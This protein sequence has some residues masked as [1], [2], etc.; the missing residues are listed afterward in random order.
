MARH[1]K[2]IKKQ[3]FGTAP[4]F[5][6]AISTILGA[7]MFLRF[8]YAVGN[9]GLIGAFAIIILG[10]I[11][12]IP[13]AMAIAEIATNQ[14]VEGGGEYYIISRSFGFTIGAAIGI[15]LYLSQA[16]SVAFYIIAFAQAFEPVFEYLLTLNFMH[17][18]GLAFILDDRLVSIPALFI[19]MFIVLT[20]GA[21]VGVKALYFVVGILF[22]SLIM[23]FLGSTD[24]K[25]EMSITN[26][27][28]HINNPDTFFQVFAICFPAFTGMTA[29]VGL[30]GDLQ[31]PRRSIPLGTLSATIFGMFVYFA[32]VYK[33]YAAIPPSDLAND[34]LIMQ[35]IAL[36]GPIIP[37][38]LAA[39]TV[40]SALGS[41]LV[42]PRTLQAL[43]NDEV[44]PVDSL[45]KILSRGTKE[46][47]EPFNAT[48]LT[49][50]IAII[51]VII[52]DVNFVAEIISMFFMVTYGAL[53]LISFLE[54]LS[55]DPSYRPTFRSRWY[56]SLI[57]AVSCLII[58]FQINT[59]YAIL[60]IL[61]MGFIYWGLSRYQHKYQQRGIAYLF[62]NT[63]IQ[64]SR[65]I[66]VYLQKRVIDEDDA[67]NWRPLII[68][69][70]THSFERASAFNLLR[71]IAYK[72]G[73]GTYIHYIPGYLSK[74]SHAKSKEMLNQ[75]IRMADITQ[76]NIYLDTLVSPSL[77]STIAQVIQLPS[78]S[79]QDNNMI[80][81]EF[82]KQHPDD[83]LP[84]IV[85]NFSMVKA[86]DVDVCILGSSPKNFGFYKEIHIW[87]TQYDYDIVNLMILLAY[88]IIGHPQWKKADIKL[89]VLYPDNESE[90]QRNQLI[91]MIDSGRLPIS[92]NNVVMIGKKEDIS[93]KHIINQSSKYADLTILGIRTDNIKHEGIDVFLGYDDIGDVMFVN[94]DKP[95]RIS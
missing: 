84:K 52:G 55:G 35:E 21:D 18:T 79:G 27:S 65:R 54:H 77:T 72:F 91:D 60:S 19:L 62:Q 14:K 24:Y 9:L 43:A 86:T 38:G 68:C 41:I 82:D 66:R 50:V 90:G 2:L 39:A 87:Y 25:F 4:V 11:V 92:A 7:I 16:I 36:W 94:T 56:L 47:N 64:V 10:H 49:S 5:F 59:N 93:T 46:R 42:A 89:F 34:Q 32:I 88:I 69:L 67:E 95:K 22:L 8:G 71:W 61:I 75:L 13:T 73:V 81:L 58:M 76:S 74:E 3:G 20:R 1:E 57:G 51:F 15:A 83:D 37:I 70:S 31:S 12:T 63:I 45:N 53:C 26:L 28:N 48:L 33:L 29:G 78:A 6:T 40:S 85:E 17:E 80:M 30:S 23:F 44:F